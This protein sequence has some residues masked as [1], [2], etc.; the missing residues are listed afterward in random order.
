LKYFL[1]LGS[2][3]GRREDLLSRARKGLVG[4]GVDILR[5]SSIYE[6]EPVDYLDQP[7]FLNQVLEV[8]THLSPLDLLDSVKAI[9]VKLGRRDCIPKGPRLI[10]IDILLNEDEIFKS[11]NLI[12][13]HP[14]LHKRNFILTALREISPEILHPV[15]KVTVDQLWQSVEDTFIVKL[16]SPRYKS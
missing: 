4:I 13:P 5:S 10:D 3:R 2:N 8:K 7:L 16:Y 11:P 12:I 1:G 14:S 6:S 9:E 15:L